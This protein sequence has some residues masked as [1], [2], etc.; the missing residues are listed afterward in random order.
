M[1]DLSML[2]KGLYKILPREVTPPPVY[3]LNVELFGWLV[4]PLGRHPLRFTLQQT[5]T[6][7]LRKEEQ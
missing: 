3:A 1:E 2:P 6:K 5:E 7:G 4:D